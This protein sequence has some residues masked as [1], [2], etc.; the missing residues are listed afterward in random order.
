MYNAQR[1]GSAQNCRSTVANTRLLMSSLIYVTAIMLKRPRK[2]EGSDRRLVCV[3]VKPR[4]RRESVRYVGGG[5]T[6]TDR[7]TIA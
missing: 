4:L 1:R 7:I 2:D 6:G 3:V 5:P